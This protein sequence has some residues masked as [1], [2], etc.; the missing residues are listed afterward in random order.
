MSGI[1][2]L[3]DDDDAALLTLAAL[4]EDAG[5]T[6]HTATDLESATT[7]L[8]AGVPFDLVITDHHLGHDDGVMLA[9]LVRRL[10]PH[11]SLAI[12]SG[13]GPPNELDEIDA[14]L[15]KAEAPERTVARVRALVEDAVRRAAGA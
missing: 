6:V 7:E 3:I 14:W 4:L 15:I 10:H 1:I 5:F 8:E 12:C 2:L 9:P 11:A 13:S